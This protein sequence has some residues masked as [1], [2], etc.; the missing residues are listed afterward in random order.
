MEK[1]LSKE[2]AKHERAVNLI[3]AKIEQVEKMRTNRT[4]LAHELSEAE[5]KENRV[6][7]LV[8]SDDVA[9]S[10][11]A[12]P[13]SEAANL[14]ALVAELDTDIAALVTEIARE[15]IAVAEAAQLAILRGF[16]QT[17]DESAALFH[18]S[19]NQAADAFIELFA[20]MMRKRA[21][22][23]RARSEAAALVLSLFNALPR[24]EGVYRTGHEARVAHAEKL[25]AEVS[26][27]GTS[28]ENLWGALPHDRPFA[29]GN[30][31]VSDVPSDGEFVALMNLIIAGNGSVRV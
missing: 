6:R 13:Q 3:A 17:A 27:D 20:D 29:G 11:L 19:R 7:S 25:L 18:R 10:E 23:E 28:V 30:L 8:K 22:W 9:A 5:A 2:L 16:A 21:L 4:R 24:D 14:R 12:K 26:A 31:P 1:E 15:R